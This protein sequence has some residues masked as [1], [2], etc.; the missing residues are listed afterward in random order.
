[1]SFIFP[2]LLLLLLIPL[3]MGTRRQKRQMQEM[4]QMQDSLRIGDE[5]MTTAGLHA[6]VSDLQE[7]TVDLRIAPGVVTRW[8][9]MVI[10]ER[11]NV[12]DEIDLDEIDIDGFDDA[13]GE[14]G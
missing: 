5:V 7:T 4:Q 8:E 12:E 11:L 3:F 14:R 10:R 13:D 9:R 6:V 1:M 2:L